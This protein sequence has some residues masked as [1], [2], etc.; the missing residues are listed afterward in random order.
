MQQLEQDL[1]SESGN[2]IR[3]IQ[4]DTKDRA[5]REARRIITMAIERYAGDQVNE[6]TTSTVT[7]PSDDMKGRI[8]GREG[9]NIRSF[10]A[11]TGVNILIDDTPEVVVI[12]GFD[13]LRREIARIAL[14]RLIEDGR[15]HPARIEEVVD[16]VQAEVEETIRHAGEEAIYDLGLQGVA[17]ELVRTLG[18]L[19]FRHSYGQNVLKHSIEM[20][21]LMGTMASE[22]RLDSAQAKRIG[23]FHD[24]GKALDHKVEGGHAIIGA[25]LLKRHGESAVVYNAVAAHHGEVEPESLYANLTI[26][27]DAITAARPGAR[28]ETTEI[29]LK[30]LEKLEEISNQFRGVE[31]SYAIQAGREIRV[32]VEPTKIDDNEA[33]QMARNISKQIEQELQYPG[34]IRVTVIRETRCVEYAK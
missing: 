1:Q 7:L 33:M 6:M 12:S 28:S 31:K 29:Y 11:A 8:I 21:H 15:I 17:P 32:L 5:E 25:D 14:E 18:R 9:R 20:G 34:Q 4:E 3:R 30:R 23:L 22:L 24:I 27:A 19:K 2:L 13:P 26:A 16:K 10:E